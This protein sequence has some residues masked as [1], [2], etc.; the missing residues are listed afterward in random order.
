MPSGCYSHNTMSRNRVFSRGLAVLMTLAFAS[1]PVGAQSL[2][3]NDADAREIASYRLTME[4]YRKIAAVY[5]ELAEEQK[6]DPTYQELGRVEAELETLR[7]KEEPT[8]ADLER[9]EALSTKKEQLKNTLDKGISMKDSTTLDEFAAELNREPRVAAALA[10]AGM[11][12]REFSKFAFA[13][14]A[15]G[16]AASLQKAGMLKEQPKEVNADNLK[17]ILEH[18]AEFQRLQEDMKG[19]EKEK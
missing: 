18:E 12:A 11:S 7:K 15:A 3:Q 10:K 9:T 6:K 5:R 13:M 19:P 2:T 17:F 16:F 1:V 14:F 4:G 8:D